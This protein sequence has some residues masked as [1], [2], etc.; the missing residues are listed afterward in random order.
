M[1][2]KGF[3]AAAVVLFA[4]S[5]V[6]NAQVSELCKPTLKPRASGA[7]VADRGFSFPVA[8]PAFAPGT[9]PKVL[10]DEA[11]LNVHTAEGRYAPFVDLLRRD[12]F[13]VEP[14]RSQFSGESLAPAKILVIAVALAPKNKNL[15]WTLPA[16]SAFSKREIDAVRNWVR[17]GGSLFLIVDHMPLPGVATDLAREFGVF[18]VDGYAT[19][20][21]CSVD[22]FSFQRSDG[23]LADHPVTR[24]RDAAERVDSVRTITGG[25]FRLS[26]AATPV[27]L[28]GAET[29]VL[30]P[31]RAWEFSEATPRIPGDGLAQGAVLSFGQGRVAV[32]GEAAMFSAQVSGKERRPLGWNMPTA[33]QNPQF[34]LN[35][36][37]WLS[38]LLPEN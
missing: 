33:K 16:R 20:R 35:V 5:L 24:G 15:D 34:L 13:V 8:R 23:T 38:R 25:A 1:T 30:L 37:R 26:G 6:C 3:S 29:V 18:M 14:N 32:F 22:E 17:E 21:T 31:R 2:R 11:H 27:L 36:M 28:L 9:G 12:G 19:D 7:Q 10:F 4:H